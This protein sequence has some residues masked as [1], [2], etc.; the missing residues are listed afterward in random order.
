MGEANQLPCGD[1]TMGG[2]SGP[3]HGG[4]PEV[5]FGRNMLGLGGKLDVQFVQ[6]VTI[7]Y[8]IKIAPNIQFIN[9]IINVDTMP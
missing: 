2:P 3:C 5:H 7:F 6:G 8:G 1:L 4:K 9:N